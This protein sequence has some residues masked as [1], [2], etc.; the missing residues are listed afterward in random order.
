[1]IED[2]RTLTVNLMDSVHID[3]TGKKLKDKE[4]IKEKF[5]KFNEGFEILVSSTSQFKLNSQELKRILKTEILS[6]ILPMYQR[7][8]GRY[9]DSFKNPRK[10]IKYTPDELTDAINHMIK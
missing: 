6:L 8:Y 4:Q 5:R 1:M 7:F 2:W 9:K 10:H 3:S